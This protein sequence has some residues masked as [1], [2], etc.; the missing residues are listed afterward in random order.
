V[1]T[2]AMKKSSIIFGSGG[3]VIVAGCILMAFNL[4]W[5]AIPLVAAGAVVGTLGLI[6]EI[7]SRRK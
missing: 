6:R 5:V 7:K 3:A 4:W 1:Y 2:K